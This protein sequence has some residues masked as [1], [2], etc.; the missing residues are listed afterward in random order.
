MKF[1]T[2]ILAALALGSS[3]AHAVLLTDTEYPFEYLTSGESE[4]VTHDLRPAIPNL[5]QAVSGSLYLAFADDSSSD[6]SEWVSVALNI[7]GPDQTFASR[8][9]DGT[10]WS[11][12]WELFGLGAHAL[13]DLNTDG[14]LRVTVQS[15]GGDFW[16]KRSVLEVNAT[17][18]SVP[19][20]GTLLL[21]GSGLLAVGF[22]SRRRKAFTA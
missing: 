6:S 12:D 8:E 22:A 5:F 15:S 14:L 10:I 18:V 3:S 19:E 13:L 11:Y 9:V 4:T 21:L 20:P 17:P 1:R 16:W 2:L 7:L